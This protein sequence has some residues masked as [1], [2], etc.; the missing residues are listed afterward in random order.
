M[1]SLYFYYSAMNAGKTTNLLQAAYNYQ[2]RGMDTLLITPSVD[3]RYG[4]GIIASRIGLTA[5]AV[6]AKPDTDLFILIAEALNENSNIRC[7]LIDEIHFFR[8]IQ[9]DQLA[10]AAVKL[11][12]PILTYGLRSDF[13]GEGF[14]SSMHL[15]AIADKLIEMKTI[16]HC[17]YKAI[18]QI[19][20]D[21]YGKRVREG[22]QIEVG[23]NERYIS[24]CRKHFLEDDLT[25]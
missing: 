4:E 11:N 1:S 3:D 12:I 22:A 13:R 19:R 14:E 15:L 10:R 25:A 5:P 24:V 7:V 2:E 8:K 6:I 9:I 17:G 23:G 16:C 21:Q 18:M 20:I